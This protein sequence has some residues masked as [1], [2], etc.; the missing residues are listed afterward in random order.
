MA[1]ED[2]LMPAPYWG[3][4]YYNDYYWNDYYWH[5]GW[6]GCCYNPGYDN[7]YGHYGNTTYDGYHDYGYNPYTGNSGEAS[8]FGT[9]TPAR[10][11]LNVHSYSATTPYRQRGR[12][13]QRAIPQ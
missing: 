8:H 3:P 2:L 1:T 7:F 11:R 5:D 12:R 13:I 9:I 10:R 6:H 4:V